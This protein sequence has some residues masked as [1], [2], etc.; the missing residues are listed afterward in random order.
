MLRIANR[1]MNLC[2][3]LAFRRSVVIALVVGLF[4]GPMLN[5][6]TTRHVEE[7]EAAVAGLS[8]GFSDP[9]GL[10]P[11]VLAAEHA[12]EQSQSGD[13]SSPLADTSTVD[14]GCHGCAAFVLP[15]V[16]TARPGD[17][18]STRVAIEPAAVAGRTVPTEIRPP[19]A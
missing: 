3:A 7:A 8:L 11:D 10:L 6:L 5:A 15:L 17:L 4:A 12:A 2:R 19:C 16:V 1:M 9:A 14:H 18:T 13:R